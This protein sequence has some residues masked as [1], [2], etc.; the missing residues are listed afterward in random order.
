MTAA[1]PVPA[2]EPMPAAELLL[3][4]PSPVLR[5]RVLTELLAVPADDPEVA[6]LAGRRR[7]ELAELLAAEPA[8]LKETAW[9][10]CRLAYAGLDRRHPR[11]AE[12]AERVFARQQ[13]DGS[14]PLGA[15][16]TGDRYDTMPLQTALPLRGLAAVGYATDPRAERGYEWLLAHRLPDGGWPTGRAA[17]QPG[18]VAGYRRLPGSAG[19]R[20]NTQAVLGCLVLHPERRRAEPT[21]R[22]LDL[23]LQRETRDEWALGTEV[24]RLRGLAPPAGFITFYARFDLA[25]VL[26]LATRAG[27]S[28]ADPRLADLVEFLLARRGPAGLWEHPAHPE[29]TRWLSF[30][31][32]LS[33]RRLAGG[34]WAG[35][36][37]RVRFRADPAR[38]RY[39]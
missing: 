18:Y 36:L 21:R 1:E 6:D 5:Y 27:A 16:H 32:A 26:E 15:F 10:L 29:L 22:A 3:C 31:L 28:A 23:L 13:P 19:C 4:D 9:Q 33:L 37:P 24:A 8:G 35:L 39:E 34:D 11:V 17:G 38:R 25:Y 14:F 12:F 7:A 30:D 20:A 2:A